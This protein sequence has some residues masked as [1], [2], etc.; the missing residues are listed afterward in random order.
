MVCSG[1]TGD[2]ADVRSSMKRCPQCRRDYYDDT[3]SFCLEDGSPLVYGVLDND[4]ATAILSEAEVPAS[5]VPSE[6]ATRSFDQT[7]ASE[8]EP[9]DNCDSVTER[10]SQ[11]DH[12]AAG[13]RSFSTIDAAESRRFS[14]RSLVG[15]VVVGLVL[16]I[17]FF[18]YRYSFAPGSRQIESIAVMPF[19]N[20]S[21]DPDA[22]YLSDGMTE[23]LMG[24]LSELPNLS[25]KAR[26]SVF[27]YKGK[28]IDARTIGKD[29]NVQA[30]LYG[31][32]AKRGDQ[33]LLSLELVD[34]QTENLLWSRRYDRKQTDLIS[35]QSEIARDVSEK[36]KAKLSGAD[37]QNVARTNTE[38][39]E[40]FQLYLKGRYHYNKFTDDGYYKSI[41]YFTQ[42][43]EVDPKYAL[44][45]TGLA[46][47]YF[48]LSDQFEPPTEVM[49][50]ALAAA[51]KALALDD[52]LAEAHASLGLVRMFY[53][54][55]WAEAESEFRRS[56]D[57]DPNYA[58]GHLFYCRLLVSAGRADEAVKECELA[59]NAEPLSAV[60]S[61]YLGNVLMYANRGEDSVAQLK[62]A[63]ELDDSYA[64]S[65]FYLG[66]VYQMLGDFDKAIAEDEKAFQLNN[67][68]RYLM[69]LGGA[70]A[71]AG[72]R[73][74]ALQVLADLTQMKKERYVS[75]YFFAVVHAGLNNKEEAFELLDKAFEEHADSLAGLKTTV[76]MNNLRS[77]PRYDRLLK[78]ANLLN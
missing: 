1:K 43:T 48:G 21:G 45:Y 29:L 58:N 51:E 19:V 76:F 62:K 71:A 69:A 15:L 8:A 67:N 53:E 26:S 31:R 38:S 41:E 18:G 3:L 28:G 32:I 66:N 50:K 75:S 25:V 27:R 77:D 49:P 46:I 39:S 68:A 52:S 60:T 74:K 23:T 11:S 10:Q 56:V 24:S 9:P 33:L 36:L 2:L 5:G 7:T 35:L 57:L 12:R 40:A 17:A 13:P 47:S 16:V 4:A 20:E 34:V 22:E 72:N 42:A 6:S 73:E 70:H 63:L 30:V 64:I 78:R 44:A 65:H 55:N 61:A 54:L 59:V 37:Q 14:A